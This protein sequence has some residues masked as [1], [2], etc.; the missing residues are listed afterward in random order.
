[1]MNLRPHSPN[2]RTNAGY[3]LIEITITFAIVAL[4]TAILI[5]NLLRSLNNQKTDNCLSNLKALQAAKESWVADHPGMDITAK[6]ATCLLPYVNLGATAKNAALPTCPDGGTYTNLTN[7]FAPV[8]CSIHGVPNP[9]P[10][11]SP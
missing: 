6:P 8:T 10:S 3:T 7:P 11:P 5:P 9:T 1:M 4:L 2:T